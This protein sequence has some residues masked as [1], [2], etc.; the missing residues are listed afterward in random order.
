MRHLERF[1]VRD[2]RRVK[3]F[4]APIAA[5]LILILAGCT[6][7]ELRGYMPGDPGVTNHSDAFT[8]F[9]VNSWIILLVVGGITW[10][11][12]IWASVM[13]RRRKGEKGLPAQLRY[14][15]PIEILFTV[16]P[17]ILVAGFFA[18]T[19]REEA[20]VVSNFAEEEQ[21]VKIEVYGKQWAWDFNYLPTSNTAYDSGVYY[22]G[23]QAQEDREPSVDGERGAA[24]GTIDEAALPKLVLPVG[25]NVTLDIKSRDVIHS[26]WVVDFHYKIDNIPGHTN[27]MSFVP[28]REGT[29]MGKCAEL[30]GEYHSMMLFQVEVV[31]QAEYNAYIAELRAAGNVGAHGDDYN[32]NQNLPGTDVPEFNHESE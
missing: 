20:P 28:E 5:A 11:L 12:I 3:W 17:I 16:V 2:T 24:T 19:V 7:Q 25:A 29:Y 21:D 18:F 13:Y 31:S 15:M 32:R 8:N 23:I 4:A 22:E 14:H 30:C 9:W 10:G 6:S 26:F 27:T 1:A